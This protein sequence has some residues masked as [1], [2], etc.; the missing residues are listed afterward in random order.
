MQSAPNMELREANGIFLFTPYKG[1]LAWVFIVFGVDRLVI[2]MGYLGDDSG[3]WERIS[4]KNT[5][6]SIGTTRPKQ[7][8]G[9]NL[10]G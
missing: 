2:K 3:V 5:D 1:I 8:F 6:T 7:I 10:K 9:Y 4:N